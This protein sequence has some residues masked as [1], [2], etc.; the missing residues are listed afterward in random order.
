MLPASEYGLSGTSIAINSGYS[1]E[2]RWLYKDNSALLLTAKEEI[3]ELTKRTTELERRTNVNSD[4]ARASLLLRNAV[5]SY[6]ESNSLEALSYLQQALVVFQKKMDNELIW[7]TYFM[8]ALVNKKQGNIPLAVSSLKDSVKA[9]EAMRSTF[10]A[11]N[12][13]SL[14]VEDRLAVYELLID[15]LITTNDNEARELYSILI[16]P[17]ESRIQGKRLCIVPHGASHFLPFQALMKGDRYLIQD[18]QIF[19]SPSSSVVSQKFLY[20]D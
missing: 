5:V 14:V 10:R 19:Y 9:I 1:P 20:N 8:M 13:R 7:Q 16:A 17:V 15:L 12:I 18:H 2:G 3:D 6:D 4:Y 11:E